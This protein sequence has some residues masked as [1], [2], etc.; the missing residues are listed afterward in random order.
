MEWDQAWAITQ[1]TFGY[2]NHTLLPEALEKWPLPLFGTLLPR[3]L[4]I[5][6]EINRRFLDDVRLRASR[7][8]MQLRPAPVAHRR[9]GRA[10]RA[11]GAPRLRRQPRH[12]RRRGAAHR[13]AQAD[14]AARLPRGRAGE[15]RQRDQRRHAAALDRAEQSRLSALITRHIGDGWIADLETS[16]A[17]RAAGRRRGF[18]REWRAIKADEQARARRRSSRSAPASRSIRD[19]LFD[20]QVKRLH[21]YK[22]Q[23]LNVAAPR[24]ALQPAEARRRRGDRRRARSSSAARRRPATAWPS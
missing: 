12:Q 7:A 1:R 18:Q 13:A 10:L 17:P 4:E 15:V 3:H 2:T 11:H 20:V 16:C 6:Y 23:H 14:G 9:D 22:R 5:I 21:E 24:H 8:T 19:S